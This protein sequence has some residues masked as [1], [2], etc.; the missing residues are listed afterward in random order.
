MKLNLA[1]LANN[2]QVELKNMKFLAKNFFFEAIQ[3]F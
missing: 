2:L 1:Q 3:E